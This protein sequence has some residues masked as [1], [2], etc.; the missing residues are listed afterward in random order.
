MW[1]CASDEVP[2]LGPEG[3]RPGKAY[4]AVRPTCPGNLGI[5][6]ILRYIRTDM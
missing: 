3:G 2:Y 6:Q 5:I 4:K 1:P